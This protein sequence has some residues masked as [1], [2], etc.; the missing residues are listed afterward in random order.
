MTVYLD[1]IW[2]LNFSFDTLILYLTGIILKRKIQIWKLI[3]G[4]FLGSLIILL[5]FTPFHSYSGNPVSKLLFSV[6]MVL[7]TFGFKRLR[8]FIKTLMLFYFITFLIGGTLIGV[9]YFIT[10]DFPLS[11]SVMLASTKGFGDPVSW[12]FVLFGFPIAWYFSKQNAESIE[13]TKIQYDQ[14]IEIE[15]GLNGREYFFTG[16]ID[17]GN[18]ACDPI[19]K[20]PVMFISMKNREMEMPLFLQ[21]IAADPSSIIEKQEC[22]EPEWENRMRVIPYKVVGQDHQI[23]CAFKPDYLYLGKGENKV[24]VQKG[25]ISFTLQQLSSDDSFQCIVHPKMM[26]NIAKAG[27]EQAKLVSTSEKPCGNFPSS[28]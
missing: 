8:S 20:A 19:S 21:K 14:I 3:V 4:G 9:H 24:H 1:I 15:L 5:A 16:L 10:F 25:L 22:L 26:T 18:H 11:S 6:M 27:G 23:V 28:V 12:L 2:M 17:S 13:M 7:I